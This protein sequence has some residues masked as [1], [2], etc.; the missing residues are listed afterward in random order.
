MNRTAVR[1]SRTLHDV[2]T[3][4]SETERLVRFGRVL[5][6]ALAVRAMR[7]LDL[8]NAIGTTQSAISQWCGGSAEPSAR[9]VFAA[10]DALEM[11]PGN[12][13]ELLGY[14]PPAAR[15][16]QQTAEE[17]VV[18]SPVWSDDSKKV[19]LATMRLLATKDRT[20]LNGERSEAKPHAPARSRRKPAS[21]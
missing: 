14:L 18:H 11:G 8:A 6:E 5:A 21:G 13:S 17:L 3:Q 10:E 12:L 16:R 1:A 4:I 15:D 20:I 7:Q 9:M 19:I 2:S